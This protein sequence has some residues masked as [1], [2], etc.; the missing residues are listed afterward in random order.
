MADQSDVETALVS[1]AS[2]ALYPNGIGAPS[3]PGANCRIYR[4]WPQSTSLDNDL[5]SG[6][7]N[8]TVF[9]GH[10]PGRLT[11]RYSDCWTSTSVTPSL[12]VQVVGTSVTFAG[13]AASGQVAGIRA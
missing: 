13:Q 10:G 3:I 12:S 8:V 11:T 7:I 9:G 6:V 5:R 4:G 1:L 2:A